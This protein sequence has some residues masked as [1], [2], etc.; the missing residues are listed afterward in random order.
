MNP[1]LRRVAAVPLLLAGVP[2]FCPL[3]GTAQESSES[4]RKAVSRQ[5]PNFP[6]WARNMNIHGNVRL[7]AVVAPNGTVKSV[8]IKGGHPVLAEEAAR[9]LKQWKWEPASHE[10]REP[11]EIDFK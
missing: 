6:T 1:L 7:E 3:L 10:T 11:V 4:S 2:L 5:I 8:E 9:A